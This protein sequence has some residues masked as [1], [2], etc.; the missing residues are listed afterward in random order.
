MALDPPIDLTDVVVL[1]RELIAAG[2]DDRQIRAMVKSGE[3]H[4]VRHG[5]YV[6]GELWRSL[7][8]ADRHRV[9]VRAVL[10]RSHPSTVATH[11]SA[12]VEHGAPVWGIG[13]EEVHTTRTD[14][15]PG[16]REAGVVHHRGKML[17][18]DVEEV[19]GIRVSKAARCGVEVCASAGVESALVTVNG[20]LHARRCTVDELVALADSLKHWPDSLTTNIVLRLC[21]HRVA[22][23]GE[24]RTSH[25]CWGQRLPRPEPQVP[26]IDEYGRMFAFVDFAWPGLGVFLEFDGREKYFRFRRDGETLD[27]FLLREKRREERICQLT[28]WVCIRITWADLERPVETARRIRR[29]PDSRRSR[30]GA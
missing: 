23:A 2:H 9:L 21:D 12:A 4:R 26:V 19:N 22:S 10:R 17:E 13:L 20:L 16:R 8:A 24:S 6:S 15:M 25:L 28:G 5:A 18:D 27:Q 30:R 29:L 11:V 14:G 7:S 1:R 3:L